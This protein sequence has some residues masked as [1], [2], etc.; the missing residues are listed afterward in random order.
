M[1]ILPLILK[2]LKWIGGALEDQGG[3]VSSKRIWG[4]VILL[5]LS[6]VIDKVMVMQDIPM[7]KY[8]LIAM[9]IGVL[10]VLAL[11]VL[12]VVAKEFFLKH[13][14]PMLNKPGKQ[15]EEIIDE[16]KTQDPVN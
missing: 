15:D 8:L 10:F 7:N 16:I 2:F 13:G 3:S 12:G 1:K 14:I 6:K 4:L 9:L 5:L 11:V